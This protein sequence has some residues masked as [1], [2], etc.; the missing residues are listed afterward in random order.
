M[1]EMSVAQ[2][3]LDIVRQHVPAERAPAVTSVRVRV[4]GLSG[5]IADSL[6]FCFSAIVA[7]T[8][9]GRAR[10]EIERVA[11]ACDCQDCSARFEP[12]HLIFLCPGCGS[13]R[14]RLI[15]GNDLQVVHVELD[16]T[17]A[18]AGPPHKSDSAAGCFE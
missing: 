17:P 4:G 3:I 9:L 7:E 14:A 6:E 11:A 18:T 8:P 12:E 5:I 2:N 16:E 1:H 15:S 10:L 13:G